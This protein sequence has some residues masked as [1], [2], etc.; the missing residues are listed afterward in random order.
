[1]DDV[2]D[3]DMRMGIRWK[4]YYYKGITLAGLG[5]LLLSCVKNVDSAIFKALF[6]QVSQS[7][8]ESLPY[9]FRFPSRIKRKDLVFPSFCTT[10]HP[11]FETCLAP[12]FQLF[13]P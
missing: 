1:V 10:P 2:D 13:L 7:R 5:V 9:F 8:S 11:F 6:Q 3:V 4:G 12:L